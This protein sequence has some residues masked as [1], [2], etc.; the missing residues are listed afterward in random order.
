MYLFFANSP[1]HLRIGFFFSF[2]FKEMRVSFVHEMMPSASC[3]HHYDYDYYHRHNYILQ[4]EVFKQ[5]TEHLPDSTG[6]TITIKGG[7]KFYFRFSRKQIVV[8]PARISHNFWRNENYP[9]ARMIYSSIFSEVKNFWFQ[10]VYSVIRV[11]DD[12]FAWIWTNL[13]NIDIMFDE[14]GL[15]LWIQI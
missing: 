12:R 11:F 2:F 15:I 5:K 13:R 8:F 9:G 3:Y 14:F 10:I 4:G 7:G 1:L 6:K